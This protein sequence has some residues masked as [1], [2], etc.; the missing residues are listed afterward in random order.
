MTI[1]DNDNVLLTK[2]ITNA[3]A[4]IQGVDFYNGRILVAWGLG[5]NVAPSGIAVYDTNGDML[6]EYRATVISS[7]EPEGVCFDRETNRLLFSTITQKVF[8]IEPKV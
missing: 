1:K 6:C 2:K 5:T 3:F 7:N 8:L 4:A